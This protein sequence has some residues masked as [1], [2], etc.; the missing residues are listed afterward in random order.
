MQSK[1][2]NFELSKFKSCEL[3]FFEE[4]DSGRRA[5]STCTHCEENQEKTWWLSII[6][7]R[8]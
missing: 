4:H 3:Y 2:H 5:T 1:G 8:E 6:R 7:N